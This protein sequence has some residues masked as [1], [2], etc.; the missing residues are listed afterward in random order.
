MSARAA[1]DLIIQ[2]PDGTEVTDRTSGGYEVAGI[3]QR[4]DGGWALV[5][6]G[7][8]W[9][10]V[11]SRTSATY[12]RGAYQAMHVGQLHE[13]TAGRVRQYFGTHAVRVVSAYRPRDG[14]L[15][16]NR[17]AGGSELRK[18]RAEGFTAVAI[19]DVGRRAAYREADF[20]VSELL[21]SR[22]HLIR[23]A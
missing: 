12:G 7:N 11:K 16:M 22:G 4:E 17:N 21:D 2:A 20:Q 9:D 23:Q 8:S 5:A 18:L 10:S 13:E 15:R 3:I 1:R 14:W 6:H 19:T